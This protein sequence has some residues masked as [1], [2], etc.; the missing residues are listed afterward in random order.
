MKSNYIKE[1]ERQVDSFNT[2]DTYGRE[3]TEETSMNNNFGNDSLI[4]NINN[5]TFNTTSV[6]TENLGLSRSF[7]QVSMEKSTTDDDPHNNNIH[8]GNENDM[9]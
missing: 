9:C 2:V 3:E 4:K 5:D 6:N 1:N 8:L 7:I